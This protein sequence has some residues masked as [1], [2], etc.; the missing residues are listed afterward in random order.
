M[1]LILGLGACRE[2]E[3]KEL[4]V[5]AIGT[6][7]NEQL[8]LRE[9]L[10]KFAGDY[11]AAWSGK[12]P[13]AVAAF[14][15]PDGTLTVNNDDPAHGREAIQGIAQGFMDAFPDMVVTMD[16]LVESPDGLEFHW[17]LTG[18]YTSAEGVGK[19]VK[20][21][22]VERWQLSADGLVQTSNGSFDQDAYNRQLMDTSP[23]GP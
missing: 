15:T 20:I 8:A 1:L 16:S 4:P 6:M 11:A 2:N 5:D 10:K 21:S 7:E 23:V 14:F 3:K 13:A 12:D 19:P 17:T 18:T 9:S 22:G